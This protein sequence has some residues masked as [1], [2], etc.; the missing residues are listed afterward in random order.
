MYLYLYGCFNSRTREGC[1][2]SF[3]R[4]E[5]RRPVF[6]FTHPGG[7]RRARGVLLCLACVQF[8]FTHP[9]GVRHLD[10][11]LIRSQGTFQFTHPGGVRRYTKLSDDRVKRFQFTHPGG[12][13]RTSALAIVHAIDV[14]IHAPGRGATVWTFVQVV[15][16]V[17]F[18]SR[19]REGCDTDIFIPDAL[20]YEFQF[21]HPGG[22]RLGRYACALPCSC[23]NSRTREGCD[24]TPSTCAIR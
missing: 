1:D 10:T 2:V 7:V 18:N 15:A 14:S 12:V 20:D 5:Y 11:R 9:G 3:L 17:S 21:T 6:Q 24:M 19:T 4:S 13:R 8:Q 16:K 22:V 23:F